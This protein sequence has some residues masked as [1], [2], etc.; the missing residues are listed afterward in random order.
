MHFEDLSD[1]YCQ[2]SVTYKQNVAPKH[3]EYVRFPVEIPVCLGE[4]V[5]VQQ[6]QPSTTRSCAALSRLQT[7][8]L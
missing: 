3:Q 2:Q 1:R 8:P 5:C 4:T 6:A 7:F